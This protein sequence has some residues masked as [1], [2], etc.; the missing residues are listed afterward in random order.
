MQARIDRQSP[1]PLYFQMERHL[2]RQ[3]QNGELRTGD[4]LPNESAL[5]QIFRVSRTTVRQALAKLA[6]DG[7][8]VRRKGSGTF[9]AQAQEPEPLSCLAS[10]TREMLA[11]G[12]VPRTDIL[13][14]ERRQPGSELKE[15]LE[16]TGGAAVHYLRRLRMVDGSPVCLVDSYIPDAAAPRLRRSDF[17]PTGLRQSLIFV[18]EHVHGVQPSRGEEWSLCRPSSR[19]EAQLLSIDEETSLVRDFC[20]LRDVYDAPVLYEEAAWGTVV[21]RR[22]ARPRV[23]ALVESSAPPLG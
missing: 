12:R 5:Q 13:T 2:R 21:R 14:F 1:V 10:F 23:N 7:T 4:A 6:N 8:I 16:L 22:L 9:V 20:V 19:E 17:E 18:L 15:E 11:Q 3:I